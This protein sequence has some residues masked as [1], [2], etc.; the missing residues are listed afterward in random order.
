MFEN[1]V[2]TPQDLNFRLGIK[3]KLYL[4]R[5]TSTICQKYIASIL[6]T[7]KLNNFN[8]LQRLKAADKILSLTSRMKTL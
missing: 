8:T 5:T 2:V 7:L 1:L 6:E 4:T 3:P